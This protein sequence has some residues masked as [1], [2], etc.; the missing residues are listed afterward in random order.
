METCKRR[1]GGSWTENRRQG[2]KMPPDPCGFCVFSFLLVYPRKYSSCSIRE[3]DQ[4]NKRKT[5]TAARSGDLKASYAS[6]AK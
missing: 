5:V 1:F 2:E 6:A 4:L 3:P